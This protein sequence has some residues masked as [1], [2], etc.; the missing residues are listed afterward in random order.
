MQILINPVCLRCTSE[1][2][3]QS[4]PPSERTRNQQVKLAGGGLWQ[5]QVVTLQNS[6]WQ[7]NMD[8]NISYALKGSPCR[9]MD[10]KST[11]LQSTQKPLL[12]QQDV[13]KGLDS[14]EGRKGNKMLKC[15]VVISLFPPAFLSIHFWHCGRR[16]LGWRP[17]T[18]SM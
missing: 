15:C 9:L 13:T 2:K 16:S 3:G 11:E 7:G 17:C 1:K 12:A 10:K 4:L 5:I 8:R 6:S 18:D 14:T